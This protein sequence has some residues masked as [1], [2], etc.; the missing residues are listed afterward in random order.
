L[1]WFRVVVKV[2]NKE[3]QQQRQIGLEDRGEELFMYTSKKETLPHQDIR[4]FELPLHI[5]L[6]K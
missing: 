6:K 2:R 4:G 5:V 1:L 3:K